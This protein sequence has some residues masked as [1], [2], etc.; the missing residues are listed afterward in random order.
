MLQLRLKRELGWSRYVSKKMRAPAPSSSGNLPA[1]AAIMIM[2]CLV[3][4][5]AALWFVIFTGKMIVLA[6]G[7]LAIGIAGACTLAYRPETGV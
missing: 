5:V 6:V 4:A 1:W 3:V 2:G 7:A